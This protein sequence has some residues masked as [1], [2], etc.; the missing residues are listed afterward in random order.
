M[1]EGMVGGQ[2]LMASATQG[3]FEALVALLKFLKDTLCDENR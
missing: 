1:G 3:F 2:E